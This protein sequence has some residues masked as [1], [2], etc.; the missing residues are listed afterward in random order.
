V[1]ATFTLFQRDAA[2]LYF[3]RERAYSSGGGGAGGAAES[4]VHS[5]DHVIPAR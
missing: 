3:D 5:R 1:D 4:L 2:E